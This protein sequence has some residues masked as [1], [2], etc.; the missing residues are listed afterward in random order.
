MPVSLGGASQLTGSRETSGLWLRT[1]GP[2]SLNYLPRAIGPSRIPTSTSHSCTLWYMGVPWLKSLHGLCLTCPQ[3]WA[4]LQAPRQSHSTQLCHWYRALGLTAFL[5]SLRGLS[6]IVTPCPHSNYALHV[7]V[8]TLTSFLE[9]REPTIPVC[10][11]QRFSRLW[12]FRC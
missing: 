10:P 6:R 9:D 8:P 2:F 3:L 7:G 4:G 1:N 12:E 11:G 5:P